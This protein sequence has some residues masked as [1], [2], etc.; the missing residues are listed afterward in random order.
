MN[1]KPVIFFL[2]KSG[3]G[4]DTQ[5]ELLIKKFGFDYINTGELFRSFISRG[6]IAKFPKNSMDRYEAQEIQRIVDN[7]R[8]A[9]PFSVIRL[10][11]E[12]LLRFVK[13][14]AQSKGI[15]LVG[16]AR[17]LGEAMVL[18]D[19]FQNWPDARN[20][21][22]LISVHLKVLDHEVKRRLLS[23]RQCFTCKKIIFSDGVIPQRCAYCGGKL[24]RR[25]DDTPRGIAS[26]LDEYRKFVVPVLQFFQKHKILIEVNGEQPIQAV[27]REI[28][29]KLGLS[30]VNI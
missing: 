25:K 30:S 17:K 26:R 21:F 9:P 14:H 16:I 13:N 1:K 28:I 6:S 19:F 24:M 8:F 18:F 11:R 5:A 23:R 7:G 2:S 4:K 27:H 10:W 22:R 29:R 3:A 20:H 12:P 15:V